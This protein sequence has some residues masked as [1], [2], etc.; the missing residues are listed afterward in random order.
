[1]RLA[2]VMLEFCHLGCLSDF[3]NAAACMWDS[4]QRCS[5]SCLAAAWKCTTCCSIHSVERRALTPCKICRP[6]WAC[7]FWCFLLAAQ[8]ASVLLR[9]PTTPF[10]SLSDFLQ[11]HALASTDGPTHYPHMVTL[12]G[13]QRNGHTALSVAERCVE[14]FH[15]CRKAQNVCGCNST[16]NHHERTLRTQM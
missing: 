9:W 12:R 1:M 4:F 15:P 3:G 8:S 13:R 14:L 5:A 2:A 16:T 6:F 7:K 11:L 10:D